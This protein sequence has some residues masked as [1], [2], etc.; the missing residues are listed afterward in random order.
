MSYQRQIFIKTENGSKLITFNP[1]MKLNELKNLIEDKYNY[2]RGTYF[3]KY[4]GKPIYDNKKLSEYEI[5]YDDTIHVVIRAYFNL[6][7]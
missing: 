1:D 7:T 6:M 4:N 5:R 2:I 3:L